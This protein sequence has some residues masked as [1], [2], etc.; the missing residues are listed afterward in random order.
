MLKIGPRLTFWSSLFWSSSVQ[1]SVFFRSYG[2]DLNTLPMV[3]A[4]PQ[5]Q[6]WVY[7]ILPMGYLCHALAE[8]GWTTM[9]LSHY[10]YEHTEKSKCNE[11]RCP[12]NQSTRRY[13]SC[14]EIVHISHNCLKKNRG[15]DQGQEGNAGQPGQPGQNLWV[16]KTHDI[17]YL[18]LTLF[19]LQAAGLQ[20][21]FGSMFFG[22]L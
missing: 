18:L 2:L 8:H 16:L 7:P 14:S 10:Q 15:Y 5:A 11:C 22:E 4:Y 9:G 20:R 1:F 3:P 19:K 12:I 13:L 17:L 21:P 6:M